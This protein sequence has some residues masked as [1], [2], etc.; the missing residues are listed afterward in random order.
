ML[1]CRFKLDGLFKA[2]SF[3]SLET[4]RIIR[5]KGF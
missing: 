3:G 5:V 1:M 2:I 4:E